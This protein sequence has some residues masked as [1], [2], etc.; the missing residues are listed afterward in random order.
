MDFRKIIFFYPISLQNEN[1]KSVKE[2]AGMIQVYDTAQK[3]ATTLDYSKIRNASDRAIE[4]IKAELP[5]E[6]QTVE[7]F[8][9]VFEEMKER[10][11]ST[12]ILL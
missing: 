1:Y 5:E 10:V 11:R 3:E 7:G 2:A 6:A 9:L 4:V 8:S 12:R